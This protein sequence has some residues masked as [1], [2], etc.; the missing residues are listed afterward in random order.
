MQLL[1]FNS[2]HACVRQQK[3]FSKKK[4]KMKWNKRSKFMIIFLLYEVVLLK[5]EKNHIAIQHVNE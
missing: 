3:K 4:M 5:A 1:R 2:I